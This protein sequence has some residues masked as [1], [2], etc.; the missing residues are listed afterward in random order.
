MMLVNREQGDRS[1]IVQ[2]LRNEAIHLLLQPGDRRRIEF[3][4]TEALP[5]SLY[6]A[7][8][9]GQMGKV[10]VQDHPYMT[11]SDANGDFDITRVPNGKWTFQFWHPE[12]GSLEHI[13][14]SGRRQR[15]P[16]GRTRLKFAGGVVELGTTTVEMSEKS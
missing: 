16:N 9:N 13:Q 4:I 7:I 10:L 1:V 6:R 11:S 14:H 3:P 15:W 12:V 5:I 2:T 8:T